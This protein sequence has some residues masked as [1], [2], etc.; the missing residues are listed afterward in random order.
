MGRI[1]SADLPRRGGLPRGVRRPARGADPAPG[2]CPFSLSLWVP[3]RFILAGER[4]G[5][6]RNLALRRPLEPPA[7]SVLAGSGSP[8]LPAGALAPRPARSGRAAAIS[9]LS[10][11]LRR[12]RPGPRGARAAMCVRNADDH[13]V[14]QFTLVLAA[15][16]VLHRRTSRVIH[17]R[18]L[19]RFL[20][21]GSSL[22][23][24]LRS[25]TSGKENI[26]GGSRTGRGPVASGAAAP[27]PKGGRSDRLLRSPRPVEDRAPASRGPGARRADR[28]ARAARPR[29]PAWATPAYTRKTARWPAPLR[30]NRGAGRGRPLSLSLSRVNDPSAGSP[31]ETLLRLLL[32]LNDQVRSSSGR[33]SEAPG[34][35]RR[36]P[37]EDLTKP[38]NR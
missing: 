5:R 25:I 28:A 16:C 36:G 37:S 7:A 13:C 20:C 14:L 10:A 1:L 22:S 23:L 2:R 6:R 26:H 21:W 4:W 8:R 18:E 11:T 34:A 31:T 30:R 38:F 19:S 29:T 9:G 32:P 33:T 15:G 27:F 3:V 24:S 12:T 17:R 35:P